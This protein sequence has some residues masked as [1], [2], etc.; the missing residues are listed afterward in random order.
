MDY[1]TSKTLRRNKN[2]SELAQHSY[3]HSYKKGSSKMNLISANSG[4]FTQ[5]ELRL[6]TLM[7][8]CTA[9]IYILTEYDFL[10]LG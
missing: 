4:L 7:R 9:I 2:P 6:S 1:R 3:N 8:D 10:M 5:A